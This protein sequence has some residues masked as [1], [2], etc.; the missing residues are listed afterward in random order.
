[1]LTMLPHPFYVRCPQVAE[2]SLFLWNHEYII[3]TLPATSS[4]C[5]RSL[6]CCFHHCT[7]TAGR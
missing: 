2:R 4:P 7:L 1:M 6:R 5:M 3:I